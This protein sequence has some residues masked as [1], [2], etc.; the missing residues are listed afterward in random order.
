MTLV[1]QAISVYIIVFSLKLCSFIIRKCLGF[2]SFLFRK[3]WVFF[4]SFLHYILP[5]LYDR[6]TKDLHNHVDLPEGDWS[7]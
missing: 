6:A 7:V 1:T 5:Y 4:L 3:F 2:V